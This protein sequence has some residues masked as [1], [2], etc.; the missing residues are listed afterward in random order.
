M[1]APILLD[2]PGSKAPDTRK[3]K[4]NGESVNEDIETASEMIPLALPVR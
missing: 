3:K 1:S 2:W 4:K